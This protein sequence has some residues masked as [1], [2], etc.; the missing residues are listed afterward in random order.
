MNLAEAFAAAHAGTL[1]LAGLRWQAESIALVIAA[2]SADANIR[3]YDRDV[4]PLTSWEVEAESAIERDQDGYG[5]A[6]LVVGGMRYQVDTDLSPD[7]QPAFRLCD[8]AGC[9]HAA[10]G[11][12]VTA[13]CTGHL[14]TPTPAG[15]AR[16]SFLGR[17]A[18]ERGWQGEDGY[19]RMRLEALGDDVARAEAAE[20]RATE[21]RQYLE[22][23]RAT[24]DI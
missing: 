10:L 8:V 24:A 23:A 11:A 1:D 12:T 18:Y 22:R 20:S 4:L 9:E 17:A 15:D 13:V 7:A 5:I 14:A 21:E 2:V 16:W 3:R 6:V 19:R